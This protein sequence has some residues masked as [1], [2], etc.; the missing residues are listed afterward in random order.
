MA[1]NN[2]TESKSNANGNLGSF[3]FIVL[4]AVAI[5]YVGG[6]SIVWQQHLFTAKAFILHEHGFAVRF[7]E[8]YYGAKFTNRFFNSPVISWFCL[9][10]ASGSTPG[11]F[12]LFQ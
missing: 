5:L 12:V 7:N 2:T 10:I 9:M 3:L 6:W 11:Y 4:G 8:L 1:E